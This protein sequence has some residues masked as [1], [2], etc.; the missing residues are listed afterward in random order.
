MSEQ[1]FM[2]IDIGTSGIRAA[3]FNKDGIQIK[4]SYK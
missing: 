1:L 4:L 3:V 2:G